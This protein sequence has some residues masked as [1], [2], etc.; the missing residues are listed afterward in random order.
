[1]APPRRLP[2]SALRETPR[3]PD[4]AR[5]AIDRLTYGQT[6]E[7]LDELAS[8]GT[9]AFI[10]RQLDPASIDDSACE[11][12]VARFGRLY[13]PARDL[14]AG[15]AQWEV[16]NELI[17][18]TTVR[19]VLSRRQLREVMTDFWH[20][21][22]SVNSAKRRIAFLLPRDNTTMRRLALGRFEDLL[23]ESAR[24]TSMLSYLDNRTSRGDRVRPPNE[25][26]ARELLEIHTI[27]DASA[28]SEADVKAVAHVFTGWTIDRGAWEFR[29]ESGWNRLGPAASRDTLG[30]RPVAGD[31]SAENGESLIRHLARHPL[32]ARNLAHK[33]CRHFIR[34][35]IG[36]DDGTVRSVADSYLANGTDIRATLATLF[37]SGAFKE[38]RG[39]RI[40]RPNELIYAMLRATRADFPLLRDDAQR[41]SRKIREEF[42]RLDQVTFEAPSP[43]GWSYADR[44]WMDASALIARWNLAFRVAANRADGA[45]VDLGDFATGA[46]NVGEFVDE[47]GTLLTGA[48]LPEAER[49]HLL[50]HLGADAGASVDRRIMLRRPAIVGLT[51]ASPSF[52]AR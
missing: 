40:R 15:N 9:E 27:G 30:W 19:S 47:I 33:L 45:E 5:H 38:S 26:Y 23:L 3:L 1:M 43:K 42:M 10:A 37:A 35:S 48:P 22:L 28:H 21:H 11:A 41:F 13:R 18:M 51:L 8:G 44:S 29:F 4:D 24:S 34:D 46:A 12:E 20:N 7:L 52:Q 25:N 49:R 14:V 32:T 50:S 36:R 16:Q 39:T 6:P 31:G 17:G 2:R